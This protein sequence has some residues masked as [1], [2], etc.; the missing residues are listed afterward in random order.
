MREGCKCIIQWY[1]DKS[2]IYLSKMAKYFQL[3]LCAILNCQNLYN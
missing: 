3:L 2:N 1:V